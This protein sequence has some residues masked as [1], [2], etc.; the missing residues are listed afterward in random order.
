MIPGLRMQPR[1]FSAEVVPV[2]L[3]VIVLSYLLG[4]FWIFRGFA[5]A[6]VLKIILGLIWIAVGIKNTR[7]YRMAKYVKELEESNNG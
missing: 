1:Y 7:K 3:A 6:Q 2:Y 5:D 4:A